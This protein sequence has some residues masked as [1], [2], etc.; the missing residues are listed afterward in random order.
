MP[1]QSKMEDPARS[2]HFSLQSMRVPSRS[3]CRA[4]LSKLIG[5]AK[6][7]AVTTSPVRTLLQ[8]YSE[9]KR[10]EDTEISLEYEL[11]DYL[12][13]WGFFYFILLNVLLVFEMGP[14]ATEW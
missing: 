4:S 11:N 9:G 1:G 14:T 5:L 3:P 10:S 7:N 8:Y 6:S 12:E 13:V 2:S